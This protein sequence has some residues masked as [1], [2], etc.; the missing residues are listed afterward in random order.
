MPDFHV[1]M[2]MREASHRAKNLLSI[3]QVMARHTAGEVD[4]KVFAERFSRR[5]A[6]L[7]ASHDLFVAAAWRGVDVGDL[8]RAQLAPFGDLAEIRVALEGPPLGLQPA[9]AQAM[10]MALHE[11]AANAAQYGSLSSSLGAVRVQ[12]D[13]FGAGP[14]ACFSMRWFEYDGPAP[15][16]APKRGFGHTMMVE[17]VGRALDANVRLAYSSSGVLW[18]LAAPVAWTLEHGRGLGPSSSLRR[19]ASW[20]SESTGQRRRIRSRS[21]PT[22]H[23]RTQ[24]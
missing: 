3:V 11:L 5:L 16:P 24:C 13:I 12:W 17:M 7:A 22:R 21:A 19:G 14:D 8:V 18:E 23:P 4:P 2:L 9:A 20:P 1:D 15:K 10:G 6:G